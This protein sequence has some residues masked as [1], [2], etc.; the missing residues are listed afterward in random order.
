MKVLTN[1]HVP[2]SL[3]HGGVTNIVRRT[4][5]V[6]EEQG[7]EVEPL[8][9]WDENQKGDILFHFCRP[10]NSLVDYAKAKGMVVVVEQVLTGLVSRPL[11]KRR[12]QK[13]AKWAIERAAPR[14]MKEPYG[15]RA[16]DA[17]DMH[18]VPSPH[19]AS[20]VKHMFG[21]PDNKLCILPYGVDDEFLTVKPGKQSDHLICTATVTERKRVVEVAEAASLAKVPMCIVGKSYGGEDRYG[22]RFE[23]VVRQSSGLIRHI[24]HVDGR[25]QLASI[26]ANSRGFVLLSTMETV[27]QSAL[28]AAACKL[29]MLLSDL[30]WARCAFQEHALYCSV[31][32][33]P[34][35]MSAKIKSFYLECPSIRQRFPSG[36][37]IEKRAHLQDVLHALVN[38]SGGTHL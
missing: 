20:V 9:W 3:A 26:L 22:Q 28:E 13:Y 14:M 16:F 31:N 4:T 6:L 34:A 29:P 19:D 21:V 30:D 33:S 35:E 10:D 25:A 27:S 7:F 36:S 2:F 38:E 5:H 11:W 37:W 1:H 15:W 17:V 24:P 23:E 32:S 8:R 12:L 18:F